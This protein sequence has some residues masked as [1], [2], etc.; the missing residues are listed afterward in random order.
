MTTNGNELGII[1]D[2][3]WSRMK[4]HGQITKQDSAALRAIETLALRTP[5][6]EAHPELNDDHKPGC[7]GAYGSHSCDIPGCI[8]FA[9]CKQSQEDY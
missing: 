1:Q 5:T 8:W 3:L 4:K 6:P 2:A 9:R 7:F